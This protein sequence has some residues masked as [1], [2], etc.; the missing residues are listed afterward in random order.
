LRLA[1]IAAPVLLVAGEYDIWPTCAAVR[2]LAALFGHAA[3]ACLPRTGHF[4]WV[5][6]PEP[7]AALV[8]DFLAT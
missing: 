4:P 5:D 1:G 7:F 2:A 3:L 8:N 6:D